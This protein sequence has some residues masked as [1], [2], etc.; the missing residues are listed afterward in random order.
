M[1]LR[2]HPSIRRHVLQGGAIL[3]CSWV[4][5]GEHSASNVVH[6]HDPETVSF[7]F[8]SPHLFPKNAIGCFMAHKLSTKFEGTVKRMRKK[9]RVKTRKNK[10]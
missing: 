9:T 3:R 7:T 10:E 6:R 5:E 8:L 2:N 4:T 1:E